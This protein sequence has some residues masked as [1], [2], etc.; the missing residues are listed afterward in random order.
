MRI[1]M[2]PL[3]K[4]VQDGI[5]CLSFRIFVF[6]TVNLSVISY[7]NKHGQQL[8]LR[9]E[10]FCSLDG[11]RVHSCE[12]K[13]S[14]SWNTFFRP[15]MTLLGWLGVKHQYL[16]LRLDDFTGW[17]PSAAPRADV[18]DAEEEE[19]WALISTAPLLIWARLKQTI[20]R[21]RR[22]R[23]RLDGHLEV[24]WARSK[25]TIERRR[26]RRRRRRRLDGHLE[27]IWERSKQTIE[28]RRRRRRSKKKKT[29]RLTW[30]DLSTVKTDD[31]T[32]KKK[33]QEE[34]D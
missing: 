28:R 17:S 27:V 13:L 5:N 24:I 12:S 16:S 1:I 20:E 8:T 23:R 9:K 15:D 2:F 31:W 21:R 6:I 26:R 34:E 10:Y 29:K 14:K 3:A 11:F 4:G 33:K 19:R 7:Q 32:Q 22:R 30:S 25:Q 18:L